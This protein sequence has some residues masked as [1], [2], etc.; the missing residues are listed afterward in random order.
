MNKKSKEIKSNKKFFLKKKEEIYKILNGKVDDFIDFF[1]FD[2]LKD[3]SY[4]KKVIIIS[5]IF[6]DIAYDYKNKKIISILDFFS[7][8]EISII[9]YRKIGGFLDGEI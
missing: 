9:E 1:D 8:K 4:N 6:Y 2:N 5:N 7:K 3:I